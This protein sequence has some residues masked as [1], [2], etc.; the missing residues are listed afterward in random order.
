MAT[1]LDEYLQLYIFAPKKS[2]SMKKIIYALAVLAFVNSCGDKNSGTSET[3]PVDNGPLGGTYNFTA[4]TTKSYD[5]IPGSGI[6][7]TNE[8]TSTTTNHKGTISFTASTVSSKGL[9]YDFST[10][11]IKKERNTVTGAIVTTNI[12]PFTGVSG[13]VATNYSSSYTFSIAGSEMSI[14]DAQYIFNPAFLILPASKK[15]S[16]AFV[17]GVLKVTIESYNSSQRAR[18][19]CE[20]TFTKQ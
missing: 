7:T 11:G 20:A 13:G 16:Y 10:S 12:S 15:Y 18:S 1:F 6:E 2:N 9:M 5:T 3:P 19:V 4:S 17:G 14:N 8:Y